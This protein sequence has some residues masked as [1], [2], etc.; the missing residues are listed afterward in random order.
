MKKIFLLTLAF[1]MIFSLAGCG[2]DT[3][4]ETSKPAESVTLVDVTTQQGIGLKLPSDMKVQENLT[5]LN[6]KTGDVASFGVSEMG[7]TPLSAWKSENVLATYQ[8]KYKDVVIK[9]FENG[10]KI[11]GKE[12]LVS[13]LTLTTPNGNPLTMV[14]VMVADGKNNYIVSLGYGSTNTDGSLAKNQQS[15]ID[16]ITIATTPVATSVKDD[17]KEYLNQIAIYHPLNNDIIKIYTE[18]GVAKDG[19]ILAKALSETLP[20]KNNAMLE[21]MKA[22][23]P[24]TIEVKELH[25]I[26]IKAVELRKEAYA[27]LHEVLTKPATDSAVDA[28]FAKLDES[29]AKFDEFLTKAESMKKDLGA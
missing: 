10:K 20:A 7:E 28:A 23:T 2:G 9:S 29:D 16:S 27:Q 8:S 19:K 4:V 3:P 15:V 26:F 5:Y 25:N 17:F 13:K 6:S 18:A 11:N 22:Y 21:K 24:K 14:L 1:I 12:S